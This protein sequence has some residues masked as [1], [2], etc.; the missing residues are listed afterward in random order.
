M[1]KNHLL[2]NPILR[3][4][5]I[6]ISTTIVVWAPFWFNGKMDRVFANY[7]GPNYIVI[8]KCWYEKSCIGTNYS[9][10]LPLEYYPAHFPGY[11]LIIKAVNI[12]LPG[13]WA[14]L[15]VTV[16]STIA[17][18]TIFF[19]FLKHLKIKNPAWLATILLFLPARLLVLR[20]VG[21]PETLFVFAIIFSIFMFKKE[22]YLLSGLGLAMAQIT[23]SPAILLFIAYA[24]SIGAKNLPA[25]VK[26]RK[27]RWNQIISVFKKYWPI[28]LG[29][30]AIL[31]VF[32]FYQLKTADFWAYFNSG[33]NFHLFFPPFQ[34]FVSSQSW[35]GDFWLEDI[36]YIYLIGGLAVLYL[37]KK[38]RWDIVS[39]FPTIFYLSTLL[40]AHRD[41]SRYSV[42]L[43]PFWIIAFAAFLNKREFKIIFFILLP[44][45]YLYA[46]NFINYN[47]SPI[48]DWAPY[49]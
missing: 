49:R 42:P 7:D 6:L 24:I 48:A 29:P 45:I 9:L 39:V 19:L 33:D 47:V 28:A 38:Y 32:F 3:L 36:V 25:V 10:P 41:I 5:I 18:T 14:M 4:I 22:K 26:E 8:A 46:T 35:L 37:I 23:K 2:Q 11:P 43:Y 13:W 44:A 40:V 21:A 20:S 1:K 16:I 17:M 15:T 31:P 30:L 34:S 27:S 12:F